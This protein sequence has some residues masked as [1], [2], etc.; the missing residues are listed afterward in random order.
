MA[1]TAA[2]EGDWE[3]YDCDYDTLEQAAVDTVR[4]HLR[5]VGPTT[6][7][8]LHNREQAPSAHRLAFEYL[9]LCPTL[10]LA[11][12]VLQVEW[13]E[14]QSVLGRTFSE[15]LL[16]YVVAVTGLV[17]PDS[18]HNDILK[19]RLLKSLDCTIIGTITSRGNFKL[20]VAI[21]TTCV[22]VCVC[23]ATCT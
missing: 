19:V 1:Q 17:H 21:R 14:L 4:N 2:S 5:E 20:I 7:L 22:C 16:R 6:S 10:F 11:L 3:Y 15:D 8:W 12:V 23:R 9:A 13:S 18:V